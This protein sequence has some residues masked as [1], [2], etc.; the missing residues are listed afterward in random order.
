MAFHTLQDALH[1][2]MNNEPQEMLPGG[3]TWR[4]IAK[5]NL[6]KLYMIAESIAKKKNKNSRD[7]A[8]SRCVRFSCFCV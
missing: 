7:D 6:P 1:R 5:N 2:K 3:E 8:Q 4:E